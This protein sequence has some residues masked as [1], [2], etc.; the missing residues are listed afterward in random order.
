MGIAVGNDL[1][2]GKNI[3]PMRDVQS[4][5]HVLFNEEDG[6]PRFVNALDNTEKATSN[7]L[8]AS[9]IWVLVQFTARRFRMRSFRSQDSCDC[10]R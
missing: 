6:D 4:L 10:R 5:T 2:L 9:F 7:I 3:T 1:S 8:V